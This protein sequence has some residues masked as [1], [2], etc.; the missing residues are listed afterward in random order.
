[1]DNVF[2]TIE[3]AVEEIRQ[4]RILIVTDNEDRENEGDFIMA[5]DKATPEAV[6]FMISHGKGLLCQAITAQRAKELE[7][8]PMV[9]DNTSAHSTAFTVSVDAKST[10]TGISA[11]ERAATIKTIV[12]PAAGPQ[13]LLRPGHIF[14]LVA[15]DGGV[16]TRGGHTEASVD[17]PRLAGF[18]PSG[19]LCEI[20]NPDGS[21]AR[22]PQ[23]EQM[24]RQH[25]LK[26]VTVESLANWRKEHD[27]VRRI[28][29]SSLP[30]ATGEYRLIAYEN[31]LKPEQPHLAMI[32]AK[33]F[34]PDNA[35]VRVH[36]E[37]LTGEV[38]LSA[39]CDCREQLTEALQ[40][41]SSEGGVIIYL[42]QE[43][44]GIGLAEKIRAYCLQ[45]QGHDTVDANVKLG[46]EPDERN[47]AVAAAI[48]RDLGIKG[49]RLLTNNPD[50]EAA[51]K[52]EG[53]RISE[54]VRIEVKPGDS[55][56]DYLK[57]KKA[58][59]GHHLEYV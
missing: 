14:P 19:I 55:N 49:I 58:R 5:A 36:S 15:K 10:S 54:R 50:K 38:L 9:Q 30:C 33:L 26:I 35:L 21:M 44:R 32:S 27:S 25:N 40:R 59:F 39:R 6:N 47:Y 46:H 17:L 23:L 52:S 2:A 4:G 31:L 42:R 7:L 13:D 12:D 51:L 11:F 37:C 3:E 24:A 1:M 8:F 56:R 29:E 22:L 43:G 45:D 57:A 41:T 16:L 53:I 34:D 28:S 20:L 48:L 18:N